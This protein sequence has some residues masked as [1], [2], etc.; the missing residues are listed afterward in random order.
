MAISEL[1]ATLSDIQLMY[2]EAYEYLKR[3]GKREGAEEERKK[4]VEILKTIQKAYEKG[5]ECAS[6]RGIEVGIVAISA[7]VKE[8]SND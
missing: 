1:L 5:G 8:S 7:P 3:E 2:P 6:S 4:I